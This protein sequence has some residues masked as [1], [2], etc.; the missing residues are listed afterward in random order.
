MDETSATI[1][2]YGHRERR[3]LVNFKQLLKIKIMK[4]AKKSEQTRS[5]KELMNQ[6]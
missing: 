6:Q 2:E 4:K 3:P 5:I 1:K